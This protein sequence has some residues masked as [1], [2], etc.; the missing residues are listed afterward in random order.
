MSAQH[1]I[2]VLH[3]DHTGVEG[4]AEFALQRMLAVGVPW[5][6]VLALPRG[7]D[8]GVFRRRGGTPLVHHGMRQPAGASAGGLRL[9][10][11]TAR[12]GAQALSTRLLAAFRTADIVDAN[13]ARAAAYAAL[14]A[15][16]SR[17]PFVVHL[18]DM[19]DPEALG[20]AGHALMTRVVLPRVD[21][22]VADTQAV[23]ASAGPHLRPAALR[24]AIPSAS[25]I[26]RRDPAERPV[27]PLRIGMLARIDPWKGQAVLLEA[28]ADALPAG[29]AV[30]EFAGGA[31]FGHEDFVRR[32]QA[33]A[34]E[35]GIAERVRFLGHVDAVDALLDS[36]HIAVHASTR[37]EPM[38]QNVLQYLASGAATIVAD[39]GGPTEFVVDGVNG[40]RVAPRDAGLLAGALTRLAVDGPLR[41]RL[42]RAAA[43]TP[44]L[45][46]DDDAVAAHAD[47]YAEVLRRSGRGPRARG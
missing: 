33:R 22:V 23:L 32:L 8:E 6:P 41:D 43:R 28:F 40:L 29:D 47:F 16:T 2:R 31:P 9:V 30:L 18:R 39:E 20:A 17:V 7:T 35:R 15:R 5:A 13:T 25:G 12:L 37:P 42:G 4:G 14:A 45:L 44:G 11:A 34:A 24:A 1:P 21:G 10:G 36:W 27:A 19:I 46:T 26:V 38:G 3:L